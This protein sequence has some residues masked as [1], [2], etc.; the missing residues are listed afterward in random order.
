M[1]SPPPHFTTLLAQ[2]Q[3]EFYADDLEPPSDARHW[4]AA[5][6]RQFFESG[7]EYVPRTVSPPPEELPRGTHPVDPSPA[8]G[9]QL[10]WDHS[11]CE[12]LRGSSIENAHGSSLGQGL[13]RVRLVPDSGTCRVLSSS[14][15]ATAKLWRLSKREDEGGV[16]AHLDCVFQGSERWVYDVAPYWYGEAQLGVATAHTGGMMGEP[17]QLLRLWHLP[18]ERS[19]DGGPTPEAR[20]VF[21]LNSQGAEDGGAHRRGVH[22]IDAS[23]VGGFLVSSSDDRLVLWKIKQETGVLGNSVLVV[24]TSSSFASRVR[25]LQDGVSLICTGSHKADALGHPEYTR[26]IPVLRAGSSGLEEF[27]KLGCK[28]DSS[29]DATQLDMHSV[30]VAMPNRA[31][32]WDLRTPNKPVARLPVGCISALATL[33]GS[34]GAPTLIAATGEHVLCFDPRKLPVEDPKARKAPPSLATLKP[35]AD[36]KVLSC[37]DAQ[38]K[39]AGTFSS[40]DVRTC[41]GKLGFCCQAS[42]FRVGRAAFGILRGH[43]Q[44]SSTVWTTS[45]DILQSFLAVLLPSLPPLVI[46]M[47]PDTRRPLQLYTDAAYQRG[48]PDHPAIELPSKQ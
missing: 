47:K 41:R 2:L 42:A 18:S 31:H 39:A 28:T 45:L 3:A 33:Y 48:S 40:A 35:E 36:G 6:L 12:L 4:S 25:F 44:S 22:A 43:E 32:T 11:P 15:D 13:T 38:A 8:A 37:V 29:N 10:Y 26:G 23:A 19:K 5:E 14:W 9:R 30:C 24:P 16:R 34:G 17:E 27:C 21:F 1:E 20:T 46:R 7:G